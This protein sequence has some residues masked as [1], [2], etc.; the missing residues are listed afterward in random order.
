MVE[1]H[2][3]FQYVS[4]H[5]NNKCQIRENVYTEEVCF[6]E[7]SLS[8]EVDRHVGACITNIFFISLWVTSDALCSHQILVRTGRTPNL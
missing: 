1:Q 5:A 7:C 3:R 2:N 8:S 6:L 4:D